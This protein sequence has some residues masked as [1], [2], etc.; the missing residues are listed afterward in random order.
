MLFYLD[1]LH[2]GLLYFHLHFVVRHQ[3]QVL[4]ENKQHAGH[5]AHAVKLQKANECK[6]ITIQVIKFILQQN[7]FKRHFH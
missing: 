1:N 7:I 2:Y 4:K 3:L 6:A 5:F